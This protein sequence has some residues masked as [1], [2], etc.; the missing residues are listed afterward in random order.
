M[1]TRIVNLSFCPFSKLL[2]LLSRLRAPVSPLDP[3]I[4]ACSQRVCKQDAM[5]FKQLRV[6]LQVSSN[7]KLCLIEACLCN[8]KVQTTYSLAVHLRWTMHV[9]LWYNPHHDVCV[10]ARTPHSGSLH[11]NSIRTQGRP[12][13][14]T[15]MQTQCSAA[16]YI[17]WA[18]TQS[19]G[20]N[21]INATREF[22]HALVSFEDRSV[23]QHP[24]QA[25]KQL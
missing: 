20:H 12:T 18:L 9:Y 22:Q 25:R 3:K 19:C 8:Y 4:V 24:K 6:E 14:T 17:S 11:L 5:S 16:H 15:C 13:S 2:A 1:R 7:W 23:R 10:C 21:K